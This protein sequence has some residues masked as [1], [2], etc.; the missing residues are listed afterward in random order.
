MKHFEN[1]SDCKES[2]MTLIEI[3]MSLAILI[4]ITLASSGMI[5]NS[6]DMR[7]RVKNASRTN[8]RLNTITSR[9]TKDLQL[10]FLTGRDELISKS[11]T[12]SIFYTKLSSDS[13]ELR[14]TAMSHEP[15]LANSHQSDQTYIIYKIEKDFDTNMTSLFRGETKVI[16]E[17]LDDDA[18]FEVLARHVKSIK[19]WGWNGDRW[20]ERWDT[21]KSEFKN[22]L[23]KLVKIEIE[24]YDKEFFP[25]EP[26]N[27]DDAPTSIRRSIVY[28]PMSQGQAE[29]KQGS[30]SP[31]IRF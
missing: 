2:G 13:S 23:P 7:N 28:L 27:Y 31:K 12:S 4:M 26:I 14:F 6:L 9:L 10:A 18:P 29:K 20:K 30:S 3:M 19:I 25:D 17:K 22:I 8:N 11:R 16:P 21:R 1:Y 24:V 15:I 5:R